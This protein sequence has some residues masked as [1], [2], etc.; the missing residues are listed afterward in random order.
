M[1]KTKH[2]SFRMPPEYVSYIQK[3]A[4]KH[5][6]TQAK[7]VQDIIDA[8]RGNEAQV[9][10]ADAI[11]YAEGGSVSD[12]DMQ[13]LKQLG[14]STGAGIA[15]YHIS[16]YIRNQMNLDKDKGEQMMW[17]LL[18]GLGTQIIQMMLSNKE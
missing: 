12:D 9:I 16:G 18:V 10:K 5:G 7:A 2:I 14:V 17:G 6:V 15:G 1:S 11:R 8:S 13:T 4:K 3:T